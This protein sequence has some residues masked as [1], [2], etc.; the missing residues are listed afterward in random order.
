MS[1]NW[2]AVSNRPSMSRRLRPLS[3]TWV[4]P[5]SR[6]FPGRAGT[7]RKPSLKSGIELLQLRVGALLDLVVERVAVGV[8]ADGEW[9]E[10]FDAELPEALGHEVFPG[11]LLDL[12]DLGGLERGGAADDREVD[13]PEPLHRLDRLVGEA[14][15][16]AD[17]AYPVLLAEAFGEAHHAGAG[18]GADAELLVAAGA[19][20]AHVRGGVEQERAVQV[21]RRLDPL[22]EDPDLGAVAD[23]DHVPLHQHLVTGLELQ[24]LGRVAE[25][26]AD[27]VRRHLQNSRS[28]STVPSAL[29]CADARRAAQHW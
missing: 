5:T 23:P 24:H 8:D 16:A 27:L 11:D 19:E 10:V 22:V 1:T 4:T 28:Y 29:M 25:R 7:P 20:L 21:D 13:H 14:A 3:M 2:P 26:E 9:P 12:F 17:R 18:G 15:L 6:G